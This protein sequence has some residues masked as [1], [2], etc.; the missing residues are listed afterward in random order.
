MAVKGYATETQIETDLGT[1]FNATQQAQVAAWIEDAEAAI[2]HDLDTAWLTGAI[3]N[4]RHLLTFDGALWLRSYPITSVQSIVG[5]QTL[6]ASST[7]LTAGTHY[8]IVDAASARLYLPG[9]Q[10]YPY[11]D[12]SYTPVA[13]VPRLIN[14]ATRQMV[15]E[16][17]Q[18]AAAGGAGNIKSFSAFGQVSV[19]FRDE[20][21]SPTVRGLLDQMRR[22]VFA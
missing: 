13:T 18:T 6:S 5:R 12:V 2:D 20:P 11:L 1:T 14:L 21:F 10:N 8:E 17:L 9:W 19:T 22:Q 3:T 7:T 16:R 15:I 4:E